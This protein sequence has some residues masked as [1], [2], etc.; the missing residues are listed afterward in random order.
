[1]RAL[2]DLIRQGKARYLGCS[3]Y[4]AWRV[5][6]AQWTAKQLG[7]APFISCQDHYNLLVRIIDRDLIPAM[8]DYGLGLMPAFPLASGQ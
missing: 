7:T 3:N 6:E 4:P 5:V 2:D 8:Q 1:M